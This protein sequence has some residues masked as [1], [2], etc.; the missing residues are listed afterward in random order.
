[1]TSGP[2]ASGGNN[3]GGRGGGVAGGGAPGSGGNAGGAA[4]GSGG[5]SGSSSNGGAGGSASGGATG[6][7]MGGSGGGGRS[8]S[9]GGAGATD[10][11]TDSHPP[12]GPNDGSTP[13]DG[14]PTTPSGPAAALADPLPSCKR[15]V[16][17][18]DAAAFTTAVAGAMPGDCLALADG[19]YTFPRLTLTGTPEA[20]II[21][22][23]ANRGQARVPSGNIELVGASHV[24]IEGLHVTSAGTIRFQDTSFSRITRSRIIPSADDG[25][26]WITTGGS[27]THHVRI[28]RNEMANQRMV[29]N[30]IQIGV[31]VPGQVVQYIQ[32]DRNYFHDVNYSSGNGWEVIRGGY[33]H[34]APSKGYLLIER[35]LFRNADGDPETI[36]I[37]SS[38]AIVRYNTIRD[39]NGQITLRHGNRAQIYGNHMINSGSGGQGSIRVYG[40]DHKIFNNYL[41][42]SGAINLAA[43]SAEGTEETGTAHYR[44]YRTQVVHN[45]I[46]GAGVTIGGSLAPVDCT[47]ANNLI[48]GGNVGGGGQN[49]K[50]MGNLTSGGLMMVDGMWRLP[51][52]SPAIDAAATAF[53]FVTEDVDGD[54]R[55]GK[56]D[57][58]AD[59]F[60]AG[61]PMRRPLTEADVGPNAP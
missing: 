40:A 4:G 52:G 45:T 23:A 13:N 22:R 38:D 37:K 51:S 24:V 44:V 19:D 48:Q 30:M 59:E 27:K 58:G 9:G 32:V 31:A 20:P 49:T 28:D 21:I 25:G 42:N 56:A 14:G 41:V 33:S 15:T 3:G 16:A 50:T 36:S 35:N 7:N 61:P 12:G 8:G 17:V 60:A 34:L 55:T 18:A 5:S 11:S 2:G 29:G 6:N 26:S 46:V 43:G 57:V 1:G 10:A 53:D 39:T 54:K 47:I